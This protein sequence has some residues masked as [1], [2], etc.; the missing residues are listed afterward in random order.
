LDELERVSKELTKTKVELE[1]RNRAIREGDEERSALRRELELQS[2]NVEEMSLMHMEAL[3]S[4]SQCAKN[5]ADVEA[6]KKEAVAL[7]TKNAALERQLVDSGPKPQVQLLLGLEKDIDDLKKQ[8]DVLEEGGAAV[9]IGMPHTRS[10]DK[11]AAGPLPIWQ[12][13]QK[14]T[15][16]RMRDQHPLSQPTAMREPRFMQKLRMRLHRAQAD[17]ARLRG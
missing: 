15:L 9:P 12:A 14:D 8:M 2:V 7:N 17:L 4:L 11:D 10:G 13:V 6:L 16:R 5:D 3:R 1:E